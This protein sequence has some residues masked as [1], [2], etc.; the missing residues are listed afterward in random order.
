MFSFPFFVQV[1]LL[2]SSNEKAVYREGIFEMTDLKGKEFISYSFLFFCFKNAAD[3]FRG[4]KNILLYEAGS[5]RA[6]LLI[7]LACLAR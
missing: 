6:R 4:E 5:A 1:I 2:N 7:K 3:F